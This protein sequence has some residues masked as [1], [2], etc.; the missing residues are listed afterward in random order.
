MKKFTRSN[1]WIKDKSPT[2][3]LSKK[4]E[5]SSHKA[6][7]D[8]SSTFDYFTDRRDTNFVGQPEQQLW[9]TEGPMSKQRS[10]KLAEALR[11]PS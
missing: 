2:T 4:K 3:G 5:N 7:P 9:A 1:T 8:W 11:R 6:L 10:S